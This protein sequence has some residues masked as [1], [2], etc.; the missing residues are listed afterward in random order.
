MAYSNPFAGATTTTLYALNQATS[1]LALIGGVNGTPSPNLGVVT[2]VGPLGVSISAGPTA[3]DIATN[4]TAFAVLRPS[5]GASTLYTINLAT[6][7]ATPAGRS[8]MARR[9]ST[10]SRSSIRTVSR[11]RAAPIPAARIS[12]SSCWPT[13]RGGA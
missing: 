12:T 8:A 7:A 2:D 5:G 4:N 10:T 13:R 9:P 6:G 1:S 3:F 11:R